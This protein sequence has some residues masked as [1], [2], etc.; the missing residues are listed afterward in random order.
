MLVVG[1]RRGAFDLVVAG[2]PGAEIDHLASLGA[3]GAKFIS[4]REVGWL[5]ADW[6]RHRQVPCPRKL[7]D[8][9]AMRNLARELEHPGLLHEDRPLRA[10]MYAL[11]VGA[12]ELRRA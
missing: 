5:F 1:R 12:R 10:D 9:R 8:D 6:T 2:G 11:D 7:S 4:G 3:E